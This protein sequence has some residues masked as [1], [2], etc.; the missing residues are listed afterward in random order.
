MFSSFDLNDG[1]GMFM[2]LLTINI[3]FFSENH[4]QVRFFFLH[5]DTYLQYFTSLIFY[6]FFFFFFVV[7][8][9][10]ED[11]GFSN[12][13]DCELWYRF[14]ELFLNTIVWFNFCFFFFV[15]FMVS[16]KKKILECD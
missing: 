2:K 8:R 10:V 12:C 7:V 6:V 16:R 3:I 14:I 11:F 9:C 4:I 15:G 13:S 1:H 5:M